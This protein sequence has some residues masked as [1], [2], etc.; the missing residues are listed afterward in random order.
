MSRFDN[1]DT[2]ITRPRSY[3]PDYGTEAAVNSMRSELD[4][5]SRTTEDIYDAQRKLQNTVDELALEAWKNAG[6]SGYDEDRF[7]GIENKL[8]NAF[9]RLEKIERKNAYEFFQL[10]ASL[11]KVMTL[12]TRMLETQDLLSRESVMMRKE[13]S[14]CMDKLG[15]E[16]RDMN[17]VHMSFNENK[18]PLFLEGSASSFV[19]EELT[20]VY[21]M[22]D[23]YAKKMN[24]YS[25]RWK[26]RGFTFASNTGI[27]WE[28]KPGAISRGALS[29][30]TWIEYSEK[31]KEEVAEYLCFF[32]YIFTPMDMQHYLFNE[33][34][35]WVEEW[36]IL[37][38]EWR[39][40]INSFNRTLWGAARDLAGKM[41]TTFKAVHTDPWQTFTPGSGRSIEFSLIE[42]KQILKSLP[43]LCTEQEWRDAM[44][45]KLGANI[46]AYE[47]YYK[48]KDPDS[49]EELQDVKS[50]F[51]Q[52]M[53]QFSKKSS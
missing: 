36:R 31:K 1:G 52:R 49:L 12:C 14:V 35:R 21:E 50:M 4:R 40:N 41:D 26:N 44:P 8:M 51:L 46:P 25:E 42:Y 2:A 33:G 10:N 6:N 16:A 34:R 28:N 22:V 7:E 48:R 27:P 17:G 37:E 23:L 24:V 19:L 29:D 53:A 3:S 38:K 9:T 18:V 5:H 45:W 30:S 20:S 13:L 47:N 15:M 39:S 32:R 43:P 11:D